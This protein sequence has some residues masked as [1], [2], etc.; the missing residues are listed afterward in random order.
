MKIPTARLLRYCC[1][2]LPHFHCHVLYYCV[3]AFSMSKR[4]SIVSQLPRLEDMADEMHVDPRHAYAGSFNRVFD[5]FV[6]PLHN[7]QT[8]TP[9]HHMEHLLLLILT[10]VTYLIWW[11]TS[12]FFILVKI[13]PK[14]S[15]QSSSN[16]SATETLH[17][18]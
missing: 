5:R 6:S 3:S 11:A 15:I 8:R 1:T 9:C 17:R 16:A 7:A 10:L 4:D 18:S 13:A 14:R 2:V 12:L